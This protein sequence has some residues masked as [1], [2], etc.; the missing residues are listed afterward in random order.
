MEMWMMACLKC[1][2]EVKDKMF[3]EVW[4]LF[5]GGLVLTWYYSIELA[6]G[7]Q[8]RHNPREGNQQNQQ[9]YQNQ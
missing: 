4:R 8:S 3:E 2:I 7:Q 9:K 5:D 6:I 1:V